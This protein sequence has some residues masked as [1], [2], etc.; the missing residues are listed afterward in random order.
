MIFLWAYLIVAVL[1]FYPIWQWVLIN[2]AE[3]EDVNHPTPLDVAF[4]SIESFLPTILWPL[5]LAGYS[6]WRL[7]RFFYRARQHS[8]S[9][10]NHLKG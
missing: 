6:L 4:T 2:V 10:T 5:A 9:P 8:T 1:V 7:S 3:P